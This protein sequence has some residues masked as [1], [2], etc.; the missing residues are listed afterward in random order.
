MRYFNWIFRGVL[1]LA[2]L[3]L[4]VKNNQSVTL[5]YF[6]EYELRASLVVIL[7]IFF[8]AGAVIGILAMF[9]NVLQQRREISRLQSSA[10]AK[11][12][13]VDKGEKSSPT[14]TS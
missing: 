7:L 2:L 5:H 11:N 3:G 12:K 6:F 4:A 9:G 10:K 8:A 13:L 1:F 14:Q